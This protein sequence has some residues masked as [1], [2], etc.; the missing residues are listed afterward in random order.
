[1]LYSENY[2]IYS[3]VLSVTFPYNIPSFAISDGPMQAK[4]ITKLK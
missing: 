2:G 1:M 3:A 4:Q